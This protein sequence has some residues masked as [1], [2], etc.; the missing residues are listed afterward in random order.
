MERFIKAG[1]AEHISSLYFLGETIF[2]RVN[3]VVVTIH[4]MLGVVN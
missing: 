4:H 3:M 2:R 1:R